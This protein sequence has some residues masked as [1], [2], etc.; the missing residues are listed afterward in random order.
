MQRYYYKF[1]V[2]FDDV[3][4]FVR[5]IEILSTDNF[6]SF[7]TALIEAVGLKSGELASFSVCDPKWNKQKE[8]TLIDMGD[9]DPLENPAEY[10]EEDGFSTKSHLPQFVMAN[11]ILKDFIA[12]P[13][14]R[15]IYEYDFL[16]PKVFYLEL[17]KTLQVMK[18]TGSHNFPK[19]VYKSGELP[20]E[21]PKLDTLDDESYLNEE[22]DSNN[23]FEDG[24]NEEDLDLSAVDDY[25]GF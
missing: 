5:D 10:D 9:D 25:S 4:D 3:E 20:K 15:L 1:R 21:A 23:D 19:C 2:Y 22:E 11:S 18:D 24:F 16:N 7:H 8:I 12:D 6:E 17:L 14:Q 13:H